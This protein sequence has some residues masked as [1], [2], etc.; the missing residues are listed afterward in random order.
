MKKLFAML[1]VVATVLSLVAC[2][3]VAWVEDA[4]GVVTEDAAVTSGI[5]DIEE[6]TSE[7]D[8]IATNPAKIEYFQNREYKEYLVTDAS[9]VD[10]LRV[11]YESLWYN[12]TYTSRPLEYPYYRITIN[13]GDEEIVF[14]VMS[15]NVVS[16]VGLGNANVND[17]TDYYSMVD[18]IVTSRGI[19]VTEIDMPYT[20]SEVT[21]VYIYE[22]L[23]DDEIVCGIIENEQVINSLL[24]LYYKLG[25][26]IEPTDE[27]MDFYKMGFLF[28]ADGETYSF[29]VD[30]NNVVS[31][32]IFGENYKITD[33]SIDYYSALQYLGS[34]K[35]NSIYYE[36]SRAL[37]DSDSEITGT[38]EID[39]FVDDSG[40]V[41]TYSVYDSDDLDNLR[42]IYESLKYN[43]ASSDDE[44]S[45]PYYQV[46]LTIDG[47]ETEFFVSES[48]LISIGGETFTTIYG[49]DYYSLL[50]EMAENE[51]KQY[52]AVTVMHVNTSS[53]NLSKTVI[54]DD[55]D[56]EYIVSLYE[57]IGEI[58]EPTDDIFT[59]RSYYKITFRDNGTQHEF[60][61]NEDNFIQSDSLGE[62]TYV[63]TDGNDYYYDIAMLTLQEP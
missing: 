20:A 16:C 24:S 9:S 57:S 36:G 33:D 29:Y 15:E 51:G 61:I 37:F 13:S 22:V 26:I 41:P 14:S 18:D 8:E 58:A 40:I 46:M 32:S 39:Y 44:L 11:I 50:A 53:D 62:D 30:E 25:D 48:N 42:I 6:A 54:T 63:V 19:D 10:M 35:V 27:T 45:M 5:E 59:R 3:D 43:T 4:P 34:A 52:R 47:E 1:L 2:G 12:T 60:Y 7:E 31:W 21:N 23:S 49:T 38:A 28:D 55:S 56:I 17:E